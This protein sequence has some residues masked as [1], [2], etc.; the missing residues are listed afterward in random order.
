MVFVERP[1]RVERVVA[2]SVN[3]IHSEEGIMKFVV[4]AIIIIALIGVILLVWAPWVTYDF[5][6]NMVVE[7]LGGPD[8]RFHY[9]N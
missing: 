1:F 3:R 4:K 6:V 2:Q 8:A 9:L 5:A 7:Y